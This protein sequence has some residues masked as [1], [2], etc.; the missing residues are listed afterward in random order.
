MYHEFNFLKRNTVSAVRGEPAR[1]AQPQGAPGP[2]PGDADWIV[3][4]TVACTIVLQYS[5][6]SETNASRLAVHHQRRGRLVPSVLRPS[7]D[8]SSP[9]LH[10]RFA[11]RPRLAN[12]VAQN[13]R[14]LLVGSDRMIKEVQGG[15]QGGEL[16]HRRPPAQSTRAERAI[17]GGR[18]CGAHR[19]AAPSVWYR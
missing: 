6:G 8:R 3:Y 17:E 2:A 10:T 18:R 19:I 16:T 12:A 4:C 9:N 13:P 11:L 5:V 1:G 15:E 7:A 14:L